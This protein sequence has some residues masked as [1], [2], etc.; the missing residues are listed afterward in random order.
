M[1]HPL[2]ATIIKAEARFEIVVTAGSVSDEIIAIVDVA[3]VIAIT[4]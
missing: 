4:Q 3:S 2:S 1:L